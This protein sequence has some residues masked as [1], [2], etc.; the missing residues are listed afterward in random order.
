MDACEVD[1]LQDL[2]AVS[3]LYSPLEL[4]TPDRVCNSDRVLLGSNAAC[5]TCNT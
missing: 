4:W 5:F 3:H 2:N 1:G